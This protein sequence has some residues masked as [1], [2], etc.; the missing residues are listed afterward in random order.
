LS[1]AVPDRSGL[2]LKLKTSPRVARRV[3]T[4]KVM[5]P[6][7]AFGPDTRAPLKKNH[8]SFFAGDEIICEGD[9]GDE[10]YLI[11]SGRVEIRKGM[12]T[13]SPKTIAVLGK[14]DVVGE[15]ALIDAH[16]RSASVVALEDTTVSVLPRQEFEDR[17]AAMDPLLRAVY[18]VTVKR[19]RHVL[20]HGRGL[21]TYGSMSNWRT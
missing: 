11:L 2:G 13:C 7:P 19:L 4:E 21:N 12:R 18:G 5:T 10:A 14:G 9:S 3:K 6:Q 16:T 1:G 15:L 8:R 17:A 20:E